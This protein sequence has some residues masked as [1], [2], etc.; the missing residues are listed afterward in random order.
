[1]SKKLVNLA[2]EYRPTTFSEVVGQDLAVSALKRIAQSPG[3]AC[4]SIF[5]KG[6]YGSGK[7]VDVTQRISTYNGY[8]KGSDLVGDL[9]EGFTPQVIGVEQTD[10]SFRDTK[11]LFKELNVSCLRVTPFYG[12]SFAATKEHSVLALKK[13]QVFPCMT[14]VEVAR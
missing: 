1:M 12:Q 9:P 14:P 8:V 10:G 2:T 6:S 4:R 11:F 13:G 7:C 5:L 3:I